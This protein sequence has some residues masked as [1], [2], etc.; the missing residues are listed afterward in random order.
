MFGGQTR[1][2]RQRL[3]FHSKL[4]EIQG[5]RQYLFHDKSIRGSI[6]YYMSLPIVEYIRVTKR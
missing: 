4:L 3:K 6:E 5:S 2:K 1:T